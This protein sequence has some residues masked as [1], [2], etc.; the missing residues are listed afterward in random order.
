LRLNEFSNIIDNTKYNHHHYHQKCPHAC[1][2]LIS[3]LERETCMKIVTTDGDRKEVREFRER[4]KMNSSREIRAIK[5]K[6]GSFKSSE[7]SLGHFA[8]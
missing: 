2:Y 4:V 6:A 3:S 5:P 1:M 7:S 8:V